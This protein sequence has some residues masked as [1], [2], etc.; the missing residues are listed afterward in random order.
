M[1]KFNDNSFNYLIILLLLV[2]CSFSIL[3]PDIFWSINNFQSIASQIPILGVLTLSMAITMLTGGI[4]LSIIATMNSCSLVMAFYLINNPSSLFIAILLGL[5]T[6]IIIGLVNGVLIAIIRVSPILATL[7]TMTLLNGLNILLSKGSAISNF[8]E[9]VLIINSGM[10]LGVPIPLIIF[11]LLSIVLWIVLDKTTLGKSVYFI[12]NNEKASYFSGIN[13]KK[14]IILVYV[15]SSLLCVIA[16]LLMMSKLNSAKSSYGDSYLL[17]AILAA[18]LGGVNPDGGKG[19]LVGIL[20]ALVLLQT[21]ESGLNIIGVS[22]YITMALWGAL[23]IMFI[24]LQKYQFT[25]STKRK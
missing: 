24:F 12:G 8:S 1:K 14:V 3:M 10:L 20:I 15:I 23:L 6:A 13:T 16:A 5:I 4:N 22:S 11:I 2:V 18:V 19:K 7:G 25:F 21:L 17:T 9:S